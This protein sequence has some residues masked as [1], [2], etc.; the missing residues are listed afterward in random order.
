MEWWGLGF[1]LV[2]AS[3]LFLSV[4]PWQSKR[5]AVLNRAG[6][7]ALSTLAIIGLILSLI[8]LYP[9]VLSSQPGGSN[10]TSGNSTSTPQASIQVNQVASSPPVYRIYVV[11]FNG[12]LSLEKVKLVL[13]STDGNSYSS[14]LGNDQQYASNVGNLWNLSVSGPSYFTTSTAILIS[15]KNPP[16]GDQNISEIKFVDMN[17][18]GNIAIFTLP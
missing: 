6:I 2:G 15:G 14:I 18:K 11:Q 1:L 10:T 9:I 5:P 4:Y 7:V 8:T 13:N 12:N 3:L 16:L 17:T